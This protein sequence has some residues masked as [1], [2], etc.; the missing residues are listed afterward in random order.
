MPT[1]P[2]SHR[3][4]TG[5]PLHRPHGEDSQAKDIR[6]R[7]KWKKLSSWLRAKFPLC[8]SPWNCG[9]AGSAVAESVHHIESLALRPDLAHKITN[10]VPVC[11]PCHQRIEAMEGRSEDT[12]GLFGPAGTDWA[13][14]VMTALVGAAG[15]EQQKG[16]E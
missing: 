1:K 7:N 14:K 3:P 16:G 6:N 12:K 15:K 10:T 2:P 9:F 4:G 8:E 13:A 11:N 5:A